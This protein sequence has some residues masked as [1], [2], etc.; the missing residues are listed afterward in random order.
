[1]NLGL[2]YLKTR[3]VFRTRSAGKRW[4]TAVPRLVQFALDLTALTA[5][6]FLAYLLRF[7][8]RIPDRELSAAFHQLPFVV[9]IQFGVLGLA[10]V[11]RLIWRYV[12]MA[13]LKLFV[14]ATAGAAVPLFAMRLSLPETL[15]QWK[16][17]LSVIVIDSV[18][19]FGAVLGLRALRR[20][21]YEYRERRR[22]PS[23]G[24]G[25]LFATLLVGAGKAGV[26][27]AREILG[28]GD[29]D[30]DLLG[31]V[32]DDPAKHGASVHG[33]RVLG[34][35][36]DLPRLVKEMGIQQVV[37]TIARITRMDILRIIDIC[38]KIPVKLRIIPGLYEILQGKVHV[39]R[40]RNVQ[41]G[42]L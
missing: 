41:I 10:G 1:M 39:T 33:V 18:L 12:G 40:I 31:F 9:G 27:A 7:D 5:S 37:I 25:K 3:S 15:Q 8:F 22:R 26:L 13:E 21:Q 23:N 35:T 6:F 30:L 14:Y 42:D 4:K 11:Y 29:M 17:P 20:L 24:N 28:R 19:A 2:S 34:T 38:H 16:I 32:D 36:Q